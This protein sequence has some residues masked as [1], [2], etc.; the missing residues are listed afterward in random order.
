MLMYQALLN[1][2]EYKHKWAPWEEG[3]IKDKNN[4]ILCIK[5]SGI[6]N[7]TSKAHHFKGH[8]KAA[9]LDYLVIDL[10]NILVSHT[11]HKGLFLWQWMFGQLWNTLTGQQSS[12]SFFWNRKHN[13]LTHYMLTIWLIE[14]K[15]AVFIFY[16]SENLSTYP[17]INQHISD[18]LT[19]HGAHSGPGP[20]P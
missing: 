10:E 14:L 6:W 17:Q 13:K 2:K 1:L 20:G 5:N 18:V 3:C 7:I 16:I 4:R 8:L 19:T 12:V 11:M 9:H 15:C